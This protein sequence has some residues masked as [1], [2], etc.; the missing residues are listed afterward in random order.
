M[1]NRDRGPQLKKC[2]EE[3]DEADN[4]L[5]CLK[6]EQNIE[7]KSEIL[8]EERKLPSLFEKKKICGG[9]KEANF[10]YTRTGYRYIGTFRY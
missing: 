3:I 9:A 6:K 10:L 4:L 5:D 2:Q 1:L 7:N 8:S